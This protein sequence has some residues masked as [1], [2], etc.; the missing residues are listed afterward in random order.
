MHNLNSFDE[1]DIFLEKMLVFKPPFSLKI[2]DCLHLF[3]A[4]S[5]INFHG[6]RH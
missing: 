3:A 1:N 4:F 6:I 5:C 2:P